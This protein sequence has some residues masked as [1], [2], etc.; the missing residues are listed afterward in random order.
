MDK[1]NLS[2]LSISPG[3]F[4]GAFFAPDETVCLRIFSDKPD[5]AFSGQKLEI[6]QGRFEAITESLQK[7]NEQGRG[8]YFVINYG[9]HEDA[10]ISR[11]NAQF[12]ECDDVSLEEQLA[13]IQA[14]PLEPS[15]IVK[16]RKSLHCYW[17]MKKAAVERFRHIQRKLIAQ[18]GA[19]PACVN[20]SRVFRLPGFF[21]C[22]EEPI[23]VECIKFNPELRYT[24]AELEAVLLD[25][26]E[27]PPS[28][29]V[30]ASPVK[31]RGTQKGLVSTGKRCTFLQYCK[32]HAKTLSEPDWYAM[33]SNLALF[34]GGEAAIHKLSRPYLKYSYEQTQAKIDHF[35]KSGTKPMTC[36]K[37]AQ[38]GFVCPK[39]KNGSCHCKAPAGLAFIPLEIADLKK[40]LTRV[41]TKH[42]TASDILLA[43]QFINDFL[44]NISPSVA[45]AFISENVRQHFSF[46]AN[47]IKALQSSYKEIYRVFASAQ[48]VR[49]AKSGGEVAAWYEITNRGSWK[50]LPGVLADYLAENEYVIYCADNYYMYENG[51]YDARND[52]AAQRKVRSFMNTRYA[53][54]ADIRDA[55]F[56]WQILIDKTT[57]EINVNPYLL[58][59][60][61]GLYNLQTDE[62]LPH[63]PN[64]LSTI[65]LG[66]KYAPTA[67]CPAFFWYLN[68]VLPATEIPLIQEILGYLMA[69]INKAQK[70]FVM[71]GKPESGKSTLL[72]VAQ[73]LLLRKDNVSNLT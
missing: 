12:M 44:Y 14:F 10:D 56:Q 9:G 73:D 4:L 60:E 71:V 18:F 34:E 50:F 21:H 45:D 48:E 59:F 33:I 65:R 55:E 67:E 20:E 66:G 16:T 54:A 53:L 64:I 37:I 32:T 63:D 35:H 49:R 61:N 2:G 26:P 38:N 31:D 22:K 70:S 24:Q 40:A 28:E 3:E 51:W 7:H 36:A 17:L 41:K 42:E 43:E 57:R 13:R 39:M 72:Y 52:K 15:L 46:K 29:G 5:S 25:I 27:E 19:D 23:M 30:K 11:I 47:N 6:K 8:I 69:P 58:N 62:L 1:Y 68:D